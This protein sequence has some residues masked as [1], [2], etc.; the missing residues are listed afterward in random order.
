MHNNILLCVR[1]R[2]RVPHS[3]LYTVFST[4]EDNLSPCVG[5][6]GVLNWTTLSDY[7]DVQ[8][9]ENITD[10]SDIIIVWYKNGRVC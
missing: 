8:R 1:T 6:A 7:K 4:L 10:S 3:S 2:A 9:A 5:F